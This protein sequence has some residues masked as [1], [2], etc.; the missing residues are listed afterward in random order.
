MYSIPIFENPFSQFS[1]AGLDTEKENRAP[2]TKKEE[3][4]E[5][6]EAVK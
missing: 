5:E 3:E 2:K 1:L 6:E 4:E